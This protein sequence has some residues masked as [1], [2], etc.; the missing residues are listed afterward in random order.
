MKSALALMAKLKPT[1]PLA[2]LIQLQQ[3]ALCYH[4]L[5]L[6]LRL[7]AGSS[8]LARQNFA[9]KTS[10]IEPAPHALPLVQNQF[11]AARFDNNSDPI[12]LTW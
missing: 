5:R 10:L 8:R 1:P 9:E 11:Q 7:L 4:L 2:Q 6:S 3:C 12:N